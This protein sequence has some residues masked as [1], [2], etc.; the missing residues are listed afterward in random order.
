MENTAIIVRRRH[1]LS[2]VN[3]HMYQ[4]LFHIHVHTCS[5]PVTLYDIK[6]VQLKYTHLT[7]RYETVRT[8]ITR[9]VELHVN[10]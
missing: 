6:P 4:Y 9:W 5:I 7:T 3:I 10:T 1:I 2:Q 8:N